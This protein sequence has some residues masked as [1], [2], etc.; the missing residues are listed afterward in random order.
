MAHREMSEETP[1]THNYL[2][3]MDAAQRM[4]VEADCTVV[5]GYLATGDVRLI[6]IG[7][8]AVASVYGILETA[9]M[10]LFASTSGKILSQE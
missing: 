10:A 6:V 9:K 7:D 5:I 3:E 4:M 2:R 1:K 8:C